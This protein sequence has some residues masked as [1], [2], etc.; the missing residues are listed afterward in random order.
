MTLCDVL[1]IS[2]FSLPLSPSISHYINALCL[3][4]EPLDE[5]KRRIKPVWSVH[6]GSY[7]TD[8]VIGRACFHVCA[9]P[10]FPKLGA[11]RRLY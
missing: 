2:I 6:D 9:M 7:G 3:E 11:S 1:R 4:P 8:A 10:G 5:L